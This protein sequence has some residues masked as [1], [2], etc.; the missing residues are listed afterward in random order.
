ME[1]ITPLAALRVFAPKIPLVVKSAFYHSLW[2]SPTSTKWD[3]RTE[4]TI[5]IVRSFMGSSKP[6]PISKQQRLFKDPG[7]KGAIWI[8][9]VTLPPPQDALLDLLT[10][11]ID[12]SKTG[13]AQYDIPSLA[14]VEAEWTGYR[15]KAHS[16]QPRPDLSEAQHYAKLMSE[17][18]SDVIM[19]YFHGG[20]YYLGDPSSHRA[21]TSKL[22]RLTGGRCFSVR[23]RL[24]PQH[25][26]PAALL[27]ALTAYLSLLYPPPDSLH[28]PVPASKI[29]FAGDSAGGG[30][31]LALLQLLL[32]INRTSS[33]SQPLRFHNT[34][35]TLPLPIPA[36]VAVV[37][38][39]IDLTRSL[40][41]ITTNAQYD[42]LPPPLTSSAIA[43]FPAD[44]IWPTTPPR[45]DLYCNTSMLCH[46]LVSPLAA[47]DWKG[48]CP[49]WMGVGEEML[50]DECK[51]AATKIVKQG[52]PVQW[53]M[54][55]AMPHCFALL[56]D[57]SGL[58]ASVK[59]YERW[60]GFCKQVTGNAEGKLVSK[61]TW[62][63]A[64]TNKETEMDIEALAPLRE[65]EVEERMRA[66][67]EARMEGT[68][69]E[70]KLMPRL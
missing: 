55:E 43:R 11:A 14:P 16:G 20:A 45:G 63:E 53:D 34:D 44:D 47:K 27:D 69:G 31:C 52:I 57:S 32:Q 54:W 35:I 9:K 38:P 7:I 51:V 30:L 39:W 28:A 48:A 60:A 66:A 22:A 33:T 8:S 59:C 46:P 67:M 29:V 70:A 3:L 24:A 40:P 13:P 1:Q 56:F 19:L 23:Y 58:P 41:S 12:A 4:L 17:V 18:T 62:Y 21:T 15:A 61:G 65:E 10:T 2:L 26:F 68:E 5:Q 37:S 49:V 36:G 64:K 50:V 25:A 6:T 42:Y